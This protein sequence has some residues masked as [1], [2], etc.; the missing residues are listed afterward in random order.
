LLKGT[1]FE[2]RLHLRAL[3]PEEVAASASRS[4]FVARADVLA[5]LD[6]EGRAAALKLEAAIE[7]ARLGLESLGPPVHENESWARVAHA[8]YN[9][10][11][12]LYLR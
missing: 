7:T 11:E 10:K 1:L 9:L 4:D 6:P 12:F 8:L 5:A 3:S 2:A